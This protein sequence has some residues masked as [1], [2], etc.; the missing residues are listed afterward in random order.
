[1]WPYMSAMYMCQRSRQT[2]QSL[3]ELLRTSLDWRW[4]W[5]SGTVHANS[6]CSCSSEAGRRSQ[7]TRKENK[8]R[9]GLTCLIGIRCHEL[10]QIRTLERS[11]DEL[12]HG[13]WHQQQCMQTVVV[14]VHLKL[15]EEVRKHTRKTKISS[16]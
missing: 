11:I 9:Y 13:C 2:R 5:A 6:G 15:E 12:L 3:G 8:D 14:H 16:P 7:E 4:P 10:P 1:M